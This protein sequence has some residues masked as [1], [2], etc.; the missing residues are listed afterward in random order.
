MQVG[1]VFILWVRQYLKNNNLTQEITFLLGIPEWPLCPLTGARTP[2][3]DRLPLLKLK[4]LPPSPPLG[5]PSACSLHS[6][7]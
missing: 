6:V 2:R 4:V 7:P 5:V 1:K 3:A